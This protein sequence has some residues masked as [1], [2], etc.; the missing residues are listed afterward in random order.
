MVVAEK[1]EHCC[2][3]RARAARARHSRI[4]RPVISSA[5]LLGQQCASQHLRGSATAFYAAMPPA[6]KRR[7]PP[8]DDGDLLD[9]IFSGMS[10]T[11]RTLPSRPVGSRAAADES[12]EIN[13]HYMMMKPTPASTPGQ[14]L[15]K[16]VCRNAD[17][18]RVNDFET[19]MRQGD[20]I[21]RHCGAVQNVRS[22]ESLEEEH[23]T[24]AD[25]DDKDKKVRTSQDS[26]IGGGGVGNAMLSQAHRMAASLGADSRDGL[27]DR[28]RK[29]LD[30]YKEKVTSLASHFQLTGVIPQEAR[31]LCDQLVA[32]QVLHDAQ[33]GRGPGGNCRLTF[34]NRSPALVAAAVLKIAMQRNGT[35]RLYEQFK[36]A[37]KSDD[38]PG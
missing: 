6:A 5:L 27:D 19:D 24:F 13:S 31:S 22:V 34:K 30:Q 37:L 10:K 35:D 12:L 33:C 38:V 8:A 9:S 7:R 17:C 3:T 21:C 28:Q 26:G 20:R 18:G 36:S 14:V 16:M 23:R 2:Q 4:S 32:N 1:T 11:M 15:N 29:R 25:D